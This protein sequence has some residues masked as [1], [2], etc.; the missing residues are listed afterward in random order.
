MN[1]L[2]GKL[3]PIERSCEVSLSAKNKMAFVSGDYA[4]PIDNSPYLPIWERCNSM[5][6]TW[7]LHAVD[8]KIASSIIYTPTAVQIWQD[9][10]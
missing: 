1:S 10:S 9:L 3:C 6:I 5:V 2:L 4:K 7:L 8:K